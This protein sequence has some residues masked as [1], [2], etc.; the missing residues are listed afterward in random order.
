MAA[1]NYNLAI[2]KVKNTIFFWKKKI[3]DPIGVNYCDKDTHPFKINSFVLE[4]SFSHQNDLV[5]KR[6]ENL[7]CTPLLYNEKISKCNL[8]KPKWYKHGIAVV[9]DTISD[10]IMLSKEAI[11][12]LYDLP[13]IH[14]LDYYQVRED[15][16]N[17]LTTNLINELTEIKRPYIPAH[18][19][20]LL[21]SKTGCKDMYWEMNKQNVNINYQ[22]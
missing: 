11:E 12:V 1:I 22:Q 7:L 4:I 21:K 16:N 17:F 6:D 2:N 5:T 8:F 3:I 15:V 19:K 20:I 14:F 13:N 10:G 18:L 9:G